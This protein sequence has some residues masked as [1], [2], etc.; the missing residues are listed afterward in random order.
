MATCRE[1]TADR[2]GTRTVLGVE[3]HRFLNPVAA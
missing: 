3:Y 2:L 1:L